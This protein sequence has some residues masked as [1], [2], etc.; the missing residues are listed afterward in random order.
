MAKPIRISLGVCAF[1][2]RRDEATTPFIN[3]KNEIRYRLLVWKCKL[4]PI[5]K[6]VKVLIPIRC[7]LAF[8]L[9]NNKRK[10]TIELVNPPKK[11]K[12]NSGVL[13]IVMAF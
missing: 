4:K 6:A 2:T 12:Y 9:T 7:M 8:I 3:R 1:I 11:K 5:K 13:S 10:A